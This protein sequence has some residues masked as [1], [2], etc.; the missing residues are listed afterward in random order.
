MHKIN[1]KDTG[2]PI[3]FVNN[4]KMGGGGQELISPFM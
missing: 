3:L 4:N 1:S 2:F